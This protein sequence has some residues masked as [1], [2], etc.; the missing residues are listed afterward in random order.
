MLL[1]QLDS[2][3]VNLG[4]VSEFETVSRRVNAGGPYSDPEL[5]ELMVG[6]DTTYDQTIEHR[7]YYCD[8]CGR[9][10]PKIYKKTFYRKK[11][12][13]EWDG[14]LPIL[15]YAISIL[16]CC[17]GIFPLLFFHL[18]RARRPTKEPYSEWVAKCENQKCTRTN[19]VWLKDSETALPVKKNYT[20]K[21]KPATAK[22]YAYP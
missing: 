18:W 13:S 4:Y 3:G 1:S 5:N 15:V 7:Y 14:M 9:W 17:A 11:H 21:Q 12:Y 8:C 10:N 6:G 16:A 19:E 22:K 20:V 2:G